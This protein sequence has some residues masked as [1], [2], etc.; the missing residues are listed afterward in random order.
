[1]QGVNRGDSKKSKFRYLIYFVMASVLAWGTTIFVTTDVL[2]KE[3]KPVRGK[4][5]LDIFTTL[6]E[7]PVVIEPFSL[8]NHKGREFT[9]KDLK[10]KWTFLFFG[11]TFCP[12]V[13]PSTLD[14]LNGVY[15]Y[16]GQNGG[17]NDMQVVFVTVDPKR[18]TVEQL[19][20]YI[21]Y[22]NENFIGV[23]G[24][25]REI[26]RLTAQLGVSYKS[27][28][29]SGNESDDEYQFYHTTSILLIDPL[30][31]LVA[32]FAP[33]HKPEIIAADFQVISKR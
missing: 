23:T 28:N 25:E 7:E 5:S 20:G 11:Y 2:R 12:E 31:S 29:P 6:L 9:L 30:G 1:M 16:L 21:P 13:C 10:G 27:F 33:P 26:K 15:E 3:V 18:D 24:E 17:R 22:F 14:N 4:L 19:A 32:R 8:V